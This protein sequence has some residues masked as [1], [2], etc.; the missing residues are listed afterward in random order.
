M[1]NHMNGESY[2]WGGE[3][4]PVDSD[5]AKPIAESV[6]PP[7]SLLPN[8]LSHPNHGLPRTHLPFS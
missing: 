5:S 6:S 4:S 1:G 3:S 7:N 8:A 2:E